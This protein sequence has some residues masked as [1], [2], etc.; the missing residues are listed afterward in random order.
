MVLFEDLGRS[1]SENFKKKSGVAYGYGPG[2]VQAWLTEHGYGCV[3]AVK[4]DEVW[5]PVETLAP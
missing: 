1:G 4:N 2:A 5:V 3:A